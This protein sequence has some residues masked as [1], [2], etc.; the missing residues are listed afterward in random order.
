MEENNKLKMIKTILN[1]MKED[2]I[3]ESAAQCAYYVIL[4]FIPFTILLLTLI[5][6][7]NVEPQ[8]LFDIISNIIPSYMNERVLGII[9]EVYSKSI[10]TV[11]ISL[12]FMLFA[13]DKGLFALMREL[14]LIYNF[15]DNKNRSWL[16]LKLISLI[17]TIVF[18]ILV[19][20]GLV[21]MVFGKTIISTIKENSGI[22]KNYTIFSEIITQIGFLLIAFI[23]FLC[24][25][26][27]MSR[28]KLNLIKQIRGAIFASLA[29][30]IISFIFS[31][32]LEIFR[33]FST[34]YGSLT[35]LMLIMMWTYTC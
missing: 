10:G 16:Y 20:L 18:I 6:Y 4:S 28:H 2:H 3:G 27:F 22:L 15:S 31:K 11:S 17:Q 1:N 23:I 24:I 34:T 13:A 5:Q 25:Y 12:I 35:A 9:R 32:Y 29:L 7:T 33:G 14:H 30:N 19:A 8:Q 26:K 21:V